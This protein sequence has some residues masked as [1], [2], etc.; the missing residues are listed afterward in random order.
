MKLKF[1]NMAPL[2]FKNIQFSETKET[3]NQKAKK[4]NIKT[5]GNKKTR[6]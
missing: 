3:R 4:P 5:T 1:D 2:Y 6:N